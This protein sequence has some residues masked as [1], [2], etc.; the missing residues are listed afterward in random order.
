VSNSIELTESEL[1]VVCG[2]EHK[3]MGMVA[4][5]VIGGQT[6]PSGPPPGGLEHNPVTDIIFTAMGFYGA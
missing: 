4:K 2:G 6:N 1:N 3:S 5:E